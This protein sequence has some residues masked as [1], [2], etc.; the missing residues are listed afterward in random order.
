M[1]IALVGGVK[2]GLGKDKKRYVPID[3]QYSAKFDVQVLCLGHLW[4][5]V[6]RVEER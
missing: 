2:F 3:S 5:V 6:R 4:L 1:Y